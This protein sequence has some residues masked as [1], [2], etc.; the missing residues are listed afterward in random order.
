MRR[1]MLACE[2]SELAIVLGFLEARAEK[3]RLKS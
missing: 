1:E 3:E 2:G